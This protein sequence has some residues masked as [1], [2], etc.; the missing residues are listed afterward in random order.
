VV[1]NPRSLRYS[2]EVLHFQRFVGKVRGFW[3]VGVAR[4]ANSPM[5]LATIQKLLAL[6]NHALKPSFAACCN[7]SCT[8][9]TWR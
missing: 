7:V 2:S 9:E 5:G 4:M 6:L 3:V 8:W 1:D